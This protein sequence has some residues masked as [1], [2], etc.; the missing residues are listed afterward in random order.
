LASKT[1]SIVSQQLADDWNIHHGYRPLLIG[2][3]VDTTKYK[4]TCY[5]AANWINVGETDGA[6]TDK[7]GDKK[8]VKAIYVYPLAKHC[9]TLQI[10]ADQRGTRKEET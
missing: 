5:Q 9:E 2:T 4:G 10:K 7:N 1:I 8:T 3:F 6:H